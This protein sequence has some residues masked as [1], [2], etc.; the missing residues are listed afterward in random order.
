MSLAALSGCGLILS[1]GQP[2]GNIGWQHIHTTERFHEAASWVNVLAGGWVCRWRRSW[3]WRSF[4]IAGGH[5]LQLLWCLSV[6]LVAIVW[7]LVAATDSE[8]IGPAAFNLLLFGVGIATIAIGLKDSE[9]R[10]RQ[11]RDWWW[12]R[13]W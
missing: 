12:W 2:W 1:F 5:R 11:P 6:P 13:L 10:H 8:W 3:R 4:S 9:P 7:P